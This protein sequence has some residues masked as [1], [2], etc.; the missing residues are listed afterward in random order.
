MNI[1]VTTPKSEIKN[2]RKEAADVEEH[3]GHWFRTFKVLPKV[4]PGDLIYFVEDGAIRGYGVVFGIKGDQ[5]ITCATTGRQWTGHH[6]LYR[7]WR[8]LQKPVPYKGFQGYR[9]INSLPETIRQQLDQPAVSRPGS[10]A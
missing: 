10:R 7:A 1:L 6:V 2:A 5:T 8:W 4:G 3:G 9:Y